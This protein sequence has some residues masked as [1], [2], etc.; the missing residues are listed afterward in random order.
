MPTKESGISNALEEEELFDDIGPLPAK[1]GS[2]KLE[3]VNVGRI[4]PRATV[5]MKNVNSTVGPHLIGDDNSVDFSQNSS[6]HSSTK[7]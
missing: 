1:K 2:M 3:T 7:G 4:K 6:G 5:S